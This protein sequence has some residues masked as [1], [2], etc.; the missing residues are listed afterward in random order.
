MAVASANNHVTW[1]GAGA[2]PLVEIVVALIALVTGICPEAAAKSAEDQFTYAV[3]PVQFS[4][5][6]PGPA[7]APSARKKTTAP[8]KPETGLTAQEQGRLAEMMSRLT[9]K[10]RK[11][12]AKAV[13]RLTPEQR[14][15]L[16]AVLKRQLAKK[17]TASQLTKRAR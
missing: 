6:R 17:A 16:V 13:K 3:T 2:G 1:A 14:T 12:L 15:Q 4:M 5:G 11:R 10:E 8:T 9:P 7:S